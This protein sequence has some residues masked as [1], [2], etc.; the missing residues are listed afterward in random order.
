GAP[1]PVAEL[2]GLKYNAV[3]EQFAWYEALIAALPAGLRRVCRVIAPAA[4]G[5]SAALVGRDGSLCEEPGQGVA[6]SYGQAYPESVEAKFREIAGSADDF[7]RQTGSVRDYP[8]SLTLLKRLLFERMVRPQALARAECFAAWGV[9][10]GGHF[11]GPDYRAAVRASGNEHSYWMCHSGARDVTAAP[12]TPS[13]AAR[14]IGAFGRLVPEAAAVAYCPLGQAPAAQASRLGL[15]GNVLVTP[16]GHDTCL[17]HLPLNA[18]LG[19]SGGAIHLEAGSWTMA[20]LAGAATTLPADGWRRG[21]IVQGTLDGAPVVTSMYGG[22]R[23]FRWLESLFGAGAF[24]DCG[25]EAAAALERVL[26][27]RHCFVLPGTAPE[28]RGTG[29]FPSLAGRIVNRGAFLADAAGAHA[30]ASLATALTALHQVRMLC[31]A[32]DTPLV[33]TGGGSRDPHLGIILAS[34]AGRPVYSL[35]GHRG[36]A[37][38]ETTTLGAALVGKAACLGVH[39]HSLCP[40]GLSLSRFE[41]LPA[42]LETAAQE[43]R[44]LWERE[45]ERALAES[46]D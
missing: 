8:G 23:D 10:I 27:A 12:G 11:L 1:T 9:L 31:P 6:L 40:P 34:L 36:E 41:P 22:G 13:A 46:A 38:S 2:N 44:G 28:N 33:L 4:R 39:P 19:A 37:L 18:A 5:A 30:L 7:F 17:S 24:G 29:P 14:K 25:E 20:A 21:L 43:Y 42:R 3:S 15:P 16:G 26:L 35:Q 32:A 45:L